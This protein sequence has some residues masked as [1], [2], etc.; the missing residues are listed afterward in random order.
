[1]NTVSQPYTLTIQI[2]APHFCAGV[3]WEQG[4]GIVKAAPIVRYMKGWT[5]VGVQNYCTQKG[6]KYEQ[7]C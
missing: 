7:Y 6:W 2:I 4:K 3:V 5:L 1:M